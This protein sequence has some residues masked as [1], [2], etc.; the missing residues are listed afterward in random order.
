ML[1]I[2][3]EFRA[4]IVMTQQL[5]RMARILGGNDVNALSTSSALTVMS[6]RFP[7]GVATI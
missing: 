3:D 6:P 2:A 4:D 1:I 5:S 7:I